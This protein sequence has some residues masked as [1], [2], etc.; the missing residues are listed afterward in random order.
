[1][2]TDIADGDAASI[3]SYLPVTASPVKVV[4]WL[5]RAFPA[6][7]ITHGSA[8][9]HGPLDGFP[10]EQHRDGVFQ[11][12][13]ETEDLVLDYAPGWPPL[14]QLSAR[15]SPLGMKLFHQLYHAGAGYPAGVGLPEHWSAS[16]IP[17]PLAG[18]MPMEMTKTMIDDVVASFAAAAIRPYPRWA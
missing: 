8:L 17:N 10:F 18:V 5:E 6:G 7:R 12:H 11:V 15:I 16:A 2:Q 3:R 4:D 14:E 1:M 13:F 9:F